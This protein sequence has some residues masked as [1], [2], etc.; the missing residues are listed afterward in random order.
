[1]IASTSAASDAI[2]GRIRIPFRGTTN[3]SSPIT[4]GTQSRKLIIGGPPLPARHQGVKAERREAADEQQR[5]G[6]HEAGLGA[7]NDDA[8]PADD[9]DRRRDEALHDDALEDRVGEA[10]ES[11]H[12]PV[13]ELVLRLVEV[14][15][16]EQERVDA[17]GA[18]DQPRGRPRV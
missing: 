10:A 12:G 16:V 17:A 7:A 3:V 1:M 6:T 11:R 5:V 14:P 13:D 15:L 4:A 18:R 9:A 8:E 2:T